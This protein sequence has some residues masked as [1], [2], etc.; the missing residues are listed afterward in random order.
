MKSSTWKLVDGGDWN[1]KVNKFL[2]CIDWKVNGKRLRGKC[3][4]A[5]I[6][7]V[8]YGRNIKW[9]NIWH[10]EYRILATAKLYSIRHLRRL[11]QESKK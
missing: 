7:Q 1:F 6:W 11:I 10:Y 4:H 2:V 5:S 3:W 8:S 9:T